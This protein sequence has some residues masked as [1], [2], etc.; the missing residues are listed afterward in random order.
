[1]NLEGAGIHAYLWASMPACW[2]LMRA[3][4]LAKASKAPALNNPRA[5][6]YVAL[7]LFAV[8]MVAAAVASRL[9]AGSFDADR[10]DILFSALVI[11]LTL[12]AASSMK[13]APETLGISL[14]GAQSILIFAVP[15]AGLAF[16]P[17]GDLN[18]AMFAAAA[19]PSIIIAAFAVELFFRG[20]M[21]T[22]IEAARGPAT[23]ILITAAAYTAF[24][25]P[26]AWGL[27]EPAALA[28]YLAFTFLIWGCGAGALFRLSGNVF[29]IALF[30]AFWDISLRA[31]SGMNPI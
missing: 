15:A 7:A 31:F 14:R 10:A 11:A 26:S 18:V 28:V 3:T 27:F 6:Q 24:H 9:A 23:G 22:R 2:A 5:Q 1:M 12:A 29:G 30:H 17:R 25:L 20:Y 19:K 4:G 13:D 8:A 21:Q 16:P